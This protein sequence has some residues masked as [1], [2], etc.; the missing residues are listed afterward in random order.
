MKNQNQNDP[1]PA[2]K[3]AQKLVNASIDGEIT[4]TEQ[5]EL[6]RLLVS[7]DS[8]R[9]L[10]AELRAITDILNDL[11]QVEP[12]EHLQNS[13]ERQ[14]RLPLP[15]NAGATNPVFP[16]RWISAI[17]L[18]TGV[19]LAA[20]VLLT[21]GVYEMASEPITARDASSLA[22]TMVKSGPADQQ[23]VLLDSI[24]LNT[25][26]LNGLVEL[27]DKGDLFTLDVH[28]S[29]DGLSQVVVNFAGRGLEFD[30]VTSMQDPTEAVSVKDGSINLASRG[31]QH[32]TVRLK[33]TSEALQV[34]PL[35]VDFYANSELIQRSELTVSK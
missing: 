24:N 6:D 14:V 35:G 26:N 1:A 21:V 8:V 2:D 5:D 19:A 20:G 3:R 12:P 4:A 11:P 23:G 15:D 25:A 10:N 32:Y 18:R 9:N 29:S 31:E 16:G 28:L 13:I 27:R 33:R 34:A 7:S 22:G 30:G 17:W